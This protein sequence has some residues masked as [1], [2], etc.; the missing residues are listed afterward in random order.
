MVSKLLLTMF[1]VLMV[2]G[3]QLQGQTVKCTCAEV[4]GNGI[5][6][7]GKVL[8]Y[9]YE[10]DPQG[11]QVI[12]VVIGTEDGNENNYHNICMPDG[13]QF[14]IATVV[15][16]GTMPHSWEQTPHGNVA[17]SP[18]GD[19]PFAVG[20]NGPPIL[21]TPFTFGFDHAGDAHTVSWILAVGGGGESVDWGQPV[22]MGAGP[23]HGPG[24]P[25]ESQVPGL[26]TWGIIALIMLL[27]LAGGYVVRMRRSSTV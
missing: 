12:M 5:G 26:T 2:L 9:T 27:L 17:P 16:P 10:V 11:S 22:G 23:V 14:N 13:W 4:G 1:A 19:C 6:D 21:T 25:S 24:E 15:D 3:S 18:S 7:C 20:F 8:R